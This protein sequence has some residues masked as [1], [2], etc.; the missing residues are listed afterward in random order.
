MNQFNIRSRQGVLQ[1]DMIFIDG[2]P[3]VEML[4]DGP[5]ASFQAPLGASMMPPKHVSR[6]WISVTAR[7]SNML[8]G[9]AKI[10]NPHFM[11]TVNASLN[12]L[13]KTTKFALVNL[14]VMEL[15]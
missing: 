1:I 4:G 6:R 3:G 10:P 13:K 2:D 14:P 15:K 12:L 8:N 9:G 5:L 11:W 7:R